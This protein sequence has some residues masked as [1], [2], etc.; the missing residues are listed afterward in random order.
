[1]VRGH[2]AFS[3]LCSASICITALYSVCIC[4]LKEIKAGGVGCVLRGYWMAWWCCGAGV[5]LVIFEQQKLPAT[6]F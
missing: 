6:D 4:V 5:V 3:Q 1:M 2:K